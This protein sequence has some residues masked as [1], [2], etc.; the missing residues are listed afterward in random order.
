MPGSTTA[1]RAIVQA[2]AWTE[3]QDI[4]KDECVSFR[5]L[6]QALSESRKVLTRAVGGP[7]RKATLAE[8]HARELIETVARTIKDEARRE[9]FRRAV[10]IAKIPP[11]AWRCFASVL[12]ELR[13]A[14]G[15]SRSRRGMGG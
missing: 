1:K 7:P 8:K 14:E 12:A 4:I 2:S 15:P 5:E 3:I 6:E 9:R 10:A 13:E 11:E